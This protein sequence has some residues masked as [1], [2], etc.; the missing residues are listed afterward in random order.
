M[1]KLIFLLFLILAGYVGY[2]YFFGKGEDKTQARTIVQ[3]SG[4]VVK[5][6]GEFLKHQKNKYDDGEFD[7]LIEGVNKT[8]RSIKSKVSNSGEAEKDQLKKMLDELEK[9]D[10]SKLSPENQEKLEKT[11]KELKN[12]LET[13]D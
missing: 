8:V 4:D 9:L 3:E 12:L 1:R 5:S 10:P 11:K 13:K 7:H 2:L 6:I